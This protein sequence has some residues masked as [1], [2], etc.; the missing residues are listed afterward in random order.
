MIEL[1][2]TLLDIDS[3]DTS[4]DIILNHYIS[5]ANTM[6]LIYCNVSSLTGYD[7]TIAEL[8]VY[9]YQNKDSVGYTQKTEGEKSVAYELGI[10]ESIKSALPV[11]R[12]T[13]G[14]ADV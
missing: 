13:V 10:P 1:V 14:A 7:D 9:L 8:A 11:P 2:K 3:W 5:K 12:I 6:A 4:K